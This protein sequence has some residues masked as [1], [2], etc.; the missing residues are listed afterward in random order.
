VPD[1]RHRLNNKVSASGRILC[2]HFRILYPILLIPGAEELDAV[3]RARWRVGGLF[4]SN[5][6]WV[7]REELSLEEGH[8]FS[9]A[10]NEFSCHVSKGLDGV[11]AS[12]MSNTSHVLDVLGVDSLIQLF[13]CPFLFRLNYCVTEGLGGLV[14]FIS[15]FCESG[16]SLG[17]STGF[18]PPR[19]TLRLW[20]LVWAEGSFACGVDG[21]FEG[22]ELLV[23]GGAYGVSIR[24]ESG[25][26]FQPRGFVFIICSV[27]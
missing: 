24:H 11:S 17:C 5:Q 22:L 8:L 4:W 18:I 25:K 13:M 1:S 7:F 19:G 16:A 23:K 21:G 3:E 2:A 20:W 6:F 27:P 10:V 12:P 26:L 15:I 9:R 14:L